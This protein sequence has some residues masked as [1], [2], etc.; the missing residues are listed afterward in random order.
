MDSYLLNLGVYLDKTLGV[1]DGIRASRIQKNGNTKLNSTEWRK[2]AQ[3]I[4]EIG[5][6]ENGKG[7]KW[8]GQVYDA[9]GKPYWDTKGNPVADI[10]K[11]QF[12]QFKTSNGIVSKPYSQEQMQKYGKTQS[13]NRKKVTNVLDPLVQRQADLLTK[14]NKWPEGKSLKGFLAAE[15]T[16]ETK[17]INSLDGI[18][19][20]GLDAQDGHIREVGGK[21]NKNATPL[22]AKGE[23]GSHSFRSRVPQMRIQNETKSLK[24]ISKL[25]MVRAGISPTNSAAFNTYLMGNDQG[26]G[27][28]IT[29][30]DKQNIGFNGKNVDQVVENRI[31]TNNKFKALRNNHHI[32]NYH[33]V[34]NF[35]NMDDTM[36][37]PEDTFKDVYYEDLF[38]QP[39]HRGLH[40]GPFSGV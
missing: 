14:H 40:D 23:K 31:K 20:L 25:N 8:R 17:F 5:I 37:N 10:T 16:G 33:G 12:Y 13:N 38:Q 22:N 34:S 4:Y 26:T 7:G 18:K 2:I 29:R 28:H 30:V 1:T 36:Y 6:K 21:G 24:D 11:G 3:R 15:K 35:V 32:K 39:I 19:K 27:T 9:I